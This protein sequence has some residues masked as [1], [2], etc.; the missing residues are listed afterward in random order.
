MKWEEKIMIGDQSFHSIAINQIT[1]FFPLLFVLVFYLFV[2][3]FFYIFKEYLLVLLFDLV[4]YRSIHSPISWSKGAQGLEHI[5][6]KGGPKDLCL[7]GLE[8]R[9]LRGKFNWCLP[10]T[11][12][13][14]Q[15]RHG[16][17]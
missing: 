7:L 15:G 14:L 11:N 5:V 16:R 3:I 13:E 2:S 10:L 4:T 9:E 17:V 1:F 6:F 8:K 12:E